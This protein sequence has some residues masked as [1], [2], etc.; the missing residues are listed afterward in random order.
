E[1]HKIM[2]ERGQQIEAIL[3]VNKESQVLMEKIRAIIDVFEHNYL[4]EITEG[5]IVVERFIP[6]REL[7]RKII[8]SHLDENLVFTSLKDDLTTKNRLD[9]PPKFQ[10]LLNTFDG[11]KSIIEV[12]RALKWPPPYTITRTAMLQE[13]GYLKPVDISIKD[14][15][16]FQIEETHIGILLEQGGAYQMISKHWGDWGVKIVQ[17]I[18]GKH[19][20]A[21]LSERFAHSSQDKLRLV[22]LFRWLSI[23]GYINLLSDYE[24]LLIVFEE[25]FKLFRQH[26]IK[27]LGNE[28][29]FLILERIFHLDSEMANDKG[30]I[31]CVSKLV[32][33]YR[34]ELYFDKL[35][36]VMNSRSQIMMP[37]FQHAFFPFLDNVIRVLTKIIGRDAVMNLLQ[38]VIVETER[39]YGTLVYDILFRSEG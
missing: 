8:L 15:N 34:N 38:I 24:L 29:T 32:E 30:R 26:L 25:F 2:F 31:I 16:I 18:D 3:I 37:L 22:Q 23:R 5:N 4:E 36:A 13:L 12:G 28:I 19:T 10:P 20:I 39:Y 11:K 35:E 17:S 1:G 21:S 14:T 27:I 33:N 9:L 7:T 6:F